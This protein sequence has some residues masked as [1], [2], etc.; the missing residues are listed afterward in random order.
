MST[1]KLNA[2]SSAQVL[3]ATPPPFIQDVPTSPRSYMK[4]YS[5]EAS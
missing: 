1:E 2:L 3:P 5:P 4:V